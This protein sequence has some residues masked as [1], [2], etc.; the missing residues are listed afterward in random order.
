MLKITQRV[1]QLTELEPLPDEM[2]LDC[3]VELTTEDYELAGLPVP[4][5]EY[6]EDCEV[7]VDWPK[8]RYHEVQQALWNSKARFKVVPAGRRSGK[9]EFAI[10]WTIIC[11]IM[12]TRAANGRFIL[13]APTHKQAKDI[14]WDKLLS[15]IPEDLIDKISISEKTVYLVNGARIEVMG[16]D[17]PSRV[18]GSPIDGIVIDEYADIN[19]KAWES[20]VRPGLDTEGREGWAW[21]IGVPEGRNHYYDL[22]Q[23]AQGVDEDWAFFTWHSSTILSQDKVDAARRQMDPLTFKQEYEA[24]FVTYGGRCYYSFGTE[25]VKPAEYDRDLT[26]IFAFDFNRAPGIA[27]VMQEQNGETVILDEIY[28]EK[29]SNT[30]KVCDRLIAAWGHHKGEVY[31]YGDATGGAQGSAKVKGSDWDIIKYMLNDKFD[32]NYRIK[33]ANPSVRSRLNA[34]NTRCMRG[35]GVRKLFVDPK[36]KN[37]IKDFEGVL[38]TDQ[39][40]IDKKTDSKLTHLTDA[41][42]YYIDYVHPIGG[43]VTSWET[44]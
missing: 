34:M 37:V 5:E 21:L 20:N 30:E 33:R 4:G 9:T 15:M 26:L 39:G 44:A 11:A 43:N 17:K 31:A 13:A 14:F 10:R 24:E 42:G 29:N 7:E 40:D 6:E 8:L 12:F 18:E 22:A 1:K 41:I 32:M 19:P 3:D 2:Y 35:D 16:L 36:C 28:I 27:V 23:Y 38:A 25:N